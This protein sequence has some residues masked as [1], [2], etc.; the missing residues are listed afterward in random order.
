MACTLKSVIACGIILA[1]IDI[2]HG[3]STLGFYGYRFISFS[4]YLC[5]RDLEISVCQNKLYFYEQMFTMRTY[6]G[7]GEGAVTLLFDMIYIIALVKYLPCLSWMWIFKSF[8]VMG[9]N[10]F[11]ISSWLV[12]K[13]SLKEIT[14]QDEEYQRHFLLAGGWLTAIQLII[15]VIFCIIGAIF[16]YKV[17]AERRRSRRSLRSLHPRSP[18]FR[19]GNASAPPMDAYDD[20]TSYMNQALAD[21]T[22]KLPL[23]SSSTSIDKAETLKAKP[24][25]V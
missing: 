7:L 25:Q 24:T 21:S 18:K 2:L 3:L 11:Y 5:P 23:Q 9:I 8:A 15:M 17:A 6:I 22:N 10:V 16:S 14:F 20:N 19:N 1:V 4:F 12:R 13:Q